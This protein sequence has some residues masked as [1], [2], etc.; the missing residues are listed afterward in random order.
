MRLSDYI[1]D[2]LFRYECV[3][4]PDFGGF[5][6]NTKP[7]IISPYTKTFYP[8][9]KLITYNCH[10]R[11]NDGLLANYISTVDRMPYDSALN[12][13]RFEVNQW[14]EELKKT[15]LTLERLGRFSL[16]INNAIIFEPQTDINYLT[17]AYG[18]A[19]F[20]SPEIKREEYVKQVEKLEEKAPI[21]ISDRKKSSPDYLKYAAAFLIAASVIGFASNS[22]YKS[23]K[24]KQQVG[25]AQKQQKE[26]ETKIEQATFIVTDALPSVTLNVTLE[27]K[28]YHVIAGA[29]RY[30][31]NAKR[32][33]NI[34]LEKGYDARILGINQWGL[35]QVS[36]NSYTSKRDAVN[37]LIKIR[38]TENEE[39]WLLV[40]EL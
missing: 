2:L 23:Y 39:A 22:L 29:F 10:L 31:E 28:P 18:L 32:M 38:R 21:L 7:A 16:D 5:I 27:K 12:Y 8:P 6:T 17:E 20:V 9:H 24:N 30:P 37:E 26:L 14:K 34:L 25:E 4:V 13:I 33:V 36:F 40:Q 1:S 35:T 11:N 3:I 15:D 19:S